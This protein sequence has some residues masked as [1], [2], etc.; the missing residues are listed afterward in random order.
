M[1]RSYRYV[2]ANVAEISSD[3][4][5]VGSTPNLASGV[6]TLHWI[7]RTMSDLREAYN[8]ELYRERQET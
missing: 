3:L 4:I 5:V 7:D 8:G 2:R 6:E 1:S